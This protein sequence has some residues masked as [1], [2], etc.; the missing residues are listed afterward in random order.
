MTVNTKKAERRELA[1]SSFEDILKDIDLIERA[2]NDGTLR[3]TGNWTAGQIYWHCAVLLRSSIEGFPPNANPPLVLKLFAKLIKKKAVSPGGEPPAGFKLPKAL[4]TFE[5]GPH[6][7][8]ETG[9]ER[10]RGYIK[11]VTAGGKR[12]EQRSPLFGEMNHEYWT[13][14]H[15]GHCQMH[16]S[17]LHPK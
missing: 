4:E 14:I 11:D 12:M 15:I 8:F 16:F 10:L 5:P 1:F 7:S 17:F 6:V 9:A 2:H 3:H 13:N